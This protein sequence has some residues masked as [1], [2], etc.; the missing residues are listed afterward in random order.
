MK[1]NLRL[2]AAAVALLLSAACSF[3]SVAATVPDSQTNEIAV[4][5][6]TDAV[7]VGTDA[8]AESTPLA[9]PVDETKVS[10]GDFSLSGES[11]EI[12]P[13]GSVYTIVANN[14]SYDGDNIEDFKADLD[15]VFDVK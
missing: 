7:A 9:D 6:G 13:D 11:G 1:R 15:Q 2:L 5:E 4:V 14:T 12:L 10:T 3:G 8:G